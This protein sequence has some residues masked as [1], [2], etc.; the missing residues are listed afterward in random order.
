MQ[1]QVNTDNHIQ[2]DERLTEYSREVI[3]GALGRFEDRVT[4]VEAHFSDENSAKKD[5]P[6]DMRCALEA[7]LAGLDPVAVSHHG[8]SVREA[9]AGATEKLV[10]VLNGI[11]EK[12]QDRRK[13]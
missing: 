2:N 3:S 6:S 4:R 1:I 10:K 13:A 8:P 5:G 12:E 9:L 7:R 11:V